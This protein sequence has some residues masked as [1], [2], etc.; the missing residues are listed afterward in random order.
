MK[1]G[2]TEYIGR[3]GSFL[4]EDSKHCSPRKHVDFLFNHSDV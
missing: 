1:A 2:E 3:L 4:L